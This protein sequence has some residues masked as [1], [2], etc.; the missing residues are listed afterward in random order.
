[1]VS[2]FDSS[3]SD[4]YQVD[5]ITPAETVV[6]P[7]L[8]EVH[9]ERVNELVGIDEAMREVI[10]RL[11]KGDEQKR[12]VISIAGFAGLGKT[13]LAR[14]VY[15]QIQGLFDC[16]AFVSVTRN[17]D[18]RKLLKDMLYQ[19]DKEKFKEIDT[20]KLDETHLKDLVREI[21]QNKW[22]TCCP[23][24]STFVVKCFSLSFWEP[25]LL[26]TRGTSPACCCGN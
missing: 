25:V 19:F 21:T 16:A 14:A 13:T 3:I 4:R 8:T 10:A 7:R 11:T 6:D 2:E 18:T 12:V 15:D 24:I 26:Y 20:A 22:Y 23:A 1:L 9:T 5:A 17:P